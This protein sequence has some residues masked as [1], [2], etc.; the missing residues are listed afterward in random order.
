M[1]NTFTSL[2]IASP[3]VPGTFLFLPISLVPPYHLGWFFSCSQLLMLASPRLASGYFSF[4]LYSL[5]LVDIIS[6]TASILLHASHSQIYTSNPTSFPHASNSLLDLS[7]RH[8][9]DRLNSKDEF[10][11]PHSKYVPPPG[12]PILA[13]LI[14]LLRPKTLTHF[15]APFFPG[16]HSIRQKILP[17][18]PSKYLES[19][20]SL[21]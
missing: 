20:K 5:F 19:V 14:Q 6:S 8:L 21:V 10:W 9:I 18:I 2:E 1:T 15:F 3:L 12:F 17:V 7:T 16:S 4:H 11:L 13:P